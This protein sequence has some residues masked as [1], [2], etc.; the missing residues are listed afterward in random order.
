MSSHSLTLG[1]FKEQLR[2]KGNYR[3]VQRQLPWNFWCKA[4]FPVWEVR[5]VLQFWVR[6]NH[7]LTWEHLTRLARSEQTAVFFLGEFTSLSFAGS[8]EHN[9]IGACVVCVCLEGLQ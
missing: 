3:C 6:E 4:E 9:R 1:H 2:K 8:F 5:Q 7:K